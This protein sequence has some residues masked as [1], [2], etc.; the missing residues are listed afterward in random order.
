M[1]KIEI[2]EIDGQND[3][4]IEM[5]FYAFYPSPGDLERLIK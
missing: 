1:D 5:A 3:E 2:K 4:A